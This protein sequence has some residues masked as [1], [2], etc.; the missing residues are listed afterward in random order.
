MKER[1]DQLT[2]QNLI[3]LSCGDRSVLLVGDETPTE[4]EMIER[5]AKILSEYKEIASPSQAKIDMLEGEEITKLRMK[6]KCLRICMALCSQNRPDMARIVLI[7]LDVNDDLLTNDESVR[8]KCKS[9][10]DEVTYEIKRHEELNEEKVAANAAKNTD[11]RKSWLSE[12]AYV[13]STLKMSIDTNTL[14]AA[15]YANLVHQASER[16]KAL[17]KMPPMMGMFM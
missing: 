9:M 5:A 4:Q 7:D 1:L 14:N 6:E 13:M 10:L 3:D 8:A 12:V 2:L 16:N 11:P 15:I 17:A